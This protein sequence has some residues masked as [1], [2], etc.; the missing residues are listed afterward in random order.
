MI[1]RCLCFLIISLS[2]TFASS[3]ATTETNEGRFSLRFEPGSGTVEV[4]GLDEAELNRLKGLD[5]SAEVWNRIL[6]IRL[7]RSPDQPEAISIIGRYQVVGGALR[8]TPRFP[9][10]AGSRYVARFDREQLDTKLVGIKPLVL[11]FLKHK[12]PLGKQTEVVAVYPTSD[13]L[14]EN[15]LK[16]YIVFS[17]PMSRGEVYNRVHLINDS[18]QPVDRPFLELGE[19]LWNTDMT[20]ITLLLDPGRIKRGLHPREEEGPIL[21]EG[22]KYTLVVDRAWPDAQGQALSRE[23]R[24]AFRAK[25]PD[26]T[27]PNINHWTFQTPQSQTRA[28]LVV[29]FSESLDHAMLGHAFVVKVDQTLIEGSSTILDQEKIWSFVPTHP[30]N[31]GSLNLSV[32]PELEDL[33]GNSLDRAFEVDLIHPQTSQIIR[34]SIM[35]PLKDYR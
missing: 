34:Q 11:T 24:K 35:I 4:V 16:F 13:V 18:G 31:R 26:E 19:E 8:F 28:P 10:V 22:K 23:K 6:S 17:A 9:F 7:A 30:W 33:A 27:Q 2:T 15:L 25:P 21:E 3:S 5:H 29:H 14:P 12:E 32:D 20:R 1:S